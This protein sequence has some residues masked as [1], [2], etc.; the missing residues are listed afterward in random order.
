MTA[1]GLEPSYLTTAYERALFHACGIELSSKRGAPKV[2]IASSWSE[3]VPGHV[4]LDQ[5]ARSV[6]AGVREAGG[7]PL[8]FQTIALCDGICQGAG[9]RAVLPSRDVI[10]ASVE[11][12]AR[13][14]SLDALVCLASCDKIVPGMLLAAARL[15]FPTLFVTG[16]LMDEGE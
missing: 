3:L 12:T 13:A 2:G 15:D 9:G 16:G 6:A 7:I 8:P 11:L 4:H 5:L 14:Y 10:A 1:P